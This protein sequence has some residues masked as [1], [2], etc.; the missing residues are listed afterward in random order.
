MIGGW[1]FSL[2]L[3]MIAITNASTA[4]LMLPGRRLG[5]DQLHLVYY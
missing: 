2:K 4:F 1:Q 5:I 3:N